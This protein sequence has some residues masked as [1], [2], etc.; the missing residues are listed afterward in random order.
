VARNV[1]TMKERILG[2]VYKQETKVEEKKK[3]ESQ[4]C[5]AG[6]FAWERC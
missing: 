6:P 2:L 3:S 4:G 1:E 5:S